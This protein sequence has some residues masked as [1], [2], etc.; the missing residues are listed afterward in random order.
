MNDPRTNTI[1]KAADENENRMGSSP[2]TSKLQPTNAE[3]YRGAS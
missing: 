1:P 3:T 2:L